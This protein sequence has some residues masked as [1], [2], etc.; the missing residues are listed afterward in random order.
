V[1]ANEPYRKGLNY[2]QRVAAERRQ[3]ELG[4]TAT[5]RFDPASRKVSAVF[6]GA[7]GMPVTA[8]GVTATLSRPATDSMDRRAV[9]EEAGPG[10]YESDTLDLAPGAWILAIEALASGSSGEESLYRSKERLWLAP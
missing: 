4:W 2:N 3:A 1:V 5:T 6:K 7:D 8:L 9:L 10:R